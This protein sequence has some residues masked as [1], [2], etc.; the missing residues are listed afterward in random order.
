[1]D[2]DALAERIRTERTQKGLKL[3]LRKPDGNII[4]HYPRDAT[5]KALWEA[6]ANRKGY[7]VLS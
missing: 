4:N 7:V 2:I 3:V 5:Q 6:A 1:M